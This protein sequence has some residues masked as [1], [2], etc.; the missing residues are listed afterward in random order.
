[1]KRNK[2]AFIVF[3]EIVLV[4]IRNNAWWIGSPIPLLLTACYLV[5]ARCRR[6]SGFVE[7]GDATFLILR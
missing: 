4:I 7:I 5:V 2:D 6:K 1:M 3:A